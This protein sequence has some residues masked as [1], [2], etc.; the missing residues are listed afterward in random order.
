MLPSA[1]VYYDP[2]ANFITSSS[3]Y[4][5]QIKIQAAPNWYINIQ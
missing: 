2:R 4:K 3:S 5:R 1:P